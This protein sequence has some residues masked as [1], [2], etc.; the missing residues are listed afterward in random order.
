MEALLEDGVE[1]ASIGPSQHEPGSRLL[2][3]VLYGGY[4]GVLS[5]RL[6]G[7]VSGVLTMAHMRVTIW[8]ATLHALHRAS[9]G[10][11]LYIWVSPCSPCWQ[12]QGNP[13]AALDVSHAG[14]VL[15]IVLYYYC[16][17]LYYSL[18]YQSILLLNILWSTLLYYA[19]LYYTIL[20]YAI[21][22]YAILYYTILY[23][24]IL[25]YTLLCYSIV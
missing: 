13:R 20:Y 11:A 3:R 5:R 2:S 23:Y 1:A 7:C 4:M 10:G 17:I 14:S 25:Y 12:R 24:T 8:S 16:A 19:I 9:D 18:L 6:L 21:L 15:Y 22:Y